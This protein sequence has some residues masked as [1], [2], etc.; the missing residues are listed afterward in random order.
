MSVFIL[1]IFF[2]FSSR[3]R[4][5]RFD[6]DWSSDVCSSDLSARVGRRF[7]GL[8]I[9][10]V[11]PQSERDRS[12]FDRFGKFHEYLDRLV[13]PSAVN[14]WPEPAIGR[15]IPGILGGYLMGVAAASIG[16]Q[17]ATVEAI[18]DQIGQSGAEALNEGEIVA[19]VLRAYGADRAPTVKYGEGLSVR[20]KNEFSAVVNTPRST[21][22]RP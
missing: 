15:T 16:K 21:K 17:L 8:S 10:V 6:C 9:L 11:T 4:H 13:D 20:T 2:F 12:I 19:W 14:R 18:Q 3:R 22:P 5:T 1:F 7:P